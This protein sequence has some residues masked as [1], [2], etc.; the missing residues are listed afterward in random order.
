MGTHVYPPVEHACFA[1]PTPLLLFPLAVHHTTQPWPQ[2]HRPYLHHHQWVAPVF[3]HV[4]H[5][6]SSRGSGAL[7]GGIAICNLIMIVVGW[8]CARHSKLIVVFISARARCSVGRSAQ[9]AFD[10]G[11]P[12]WRSGTH[13]RP[14]LHAHGWRRATP[15]SDVCCG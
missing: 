7:H 8:T 3:R 9:R 12:P 4:I 6:R 1:H 14:L 2:Q 10:S 11:S 13:F 15:R 5:C